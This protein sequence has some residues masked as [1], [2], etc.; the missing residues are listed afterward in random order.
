[1]QS[2]RVAETTASSSP[3]GVA[4]AAASEPLCVDLDGTLVK[5]DT[6]V[7]TVVVLARQSPKTVLKF[8]GWIAEGKA[9]FKRKVSSL[10]ALDVVHLPY[11]RPL[12]EYLRQQHAEGREI[13]LTTG[14]DTLLA[15]RVAAHL[16]IFSGVL[17]S[18]GSV[19]LTGHNKLA[20]F[21]EKFPAGFCYIGNARPDVPLLTHCVH[22]MVANP[23][24]GLL[25]RL[26][27]A[28]IV[29]VRTF[30]DAASPVKTWIKA[31]R[32]HQWA[33]NVLIFLPL[34]LAHV[35]TAGPV[36]A[37]CLAFLSFGLAAS[38]TYILNDLLDLEADRHHPRKRRRPFASGDLSPIAGVATVIVFFVLSLTIALLLQRVL[39]ALS[40]A[41]PWNG[42]GLFWEWLVVY[43]VT[44]TAYSLRLKRMV[45]VDVI[46]LS[47]L[48]TIRILA[49]SAAAGVMVSP[50]LA[51]FSIFF[52][53]SLAFVKRFA[54][55]ESMKVRA[56]AEG[57]VVPVKGRGYRISDLEQLRSFG[58]ASGYASV[59]VFA[60]YI[61]NE[62]AQSLYPHH[63]RL[64]LLVPVLLLW[65]SRLWL[66]ASRG[67]LHEDPVVYAI[68][69]KRSLLL[70]VIVVGIV[71]SAL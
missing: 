55:L 19:N 48:Y 24:G 46:V 45:L 71:L 25:A 6:L 12:L 13:Y 23:H 66:Q 49:G 27:S 58:T 33:K 2:E 65:L 51:A 36:V 69:D 40:P 15:E 54:E 70:G 44:T 63:T 38:A 57:T 35:R 59:V 64:W 17:A 10:A 56:E 67:E 20:A 32:L 60:L 34:L 29:P 37:T 61:G 7:D 26:R 53:L 16:G 62:V 1:M 18:D 28:K 41:F 21:Q 22:P 52:F 43:A 42:Q 8:P 11:N 39:F 9:S 47:G 5:S 3:A 50:W 68:T 30:H 14:A 4:S 31:I